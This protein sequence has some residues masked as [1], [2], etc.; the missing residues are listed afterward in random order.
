MPGAA[1]AYN[2]R[3]PDHESLGDAMKILLL[4]SLCLGTGSAFAEAPVADEAEPL[5]RNGGNF[6]PDSSDE[7]PPH[8]PSAT[9]KATTETEPQ[10]AKIK[11]RLTEAPQ[12]AS[13]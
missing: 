2:G 6:G 9:L 4:L 1:A 7:C 13:P 5:Y 8:Q 11:T 12:P 3:R 10:A